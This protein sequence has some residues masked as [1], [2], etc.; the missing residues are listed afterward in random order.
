MPDA[1]RSAPGTS[2]RG[3]RPVGVAGRMKA[4][5]PIIASGATMTLIRNDHRHE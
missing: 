5:A 4:S 3:R 2:I 1:T